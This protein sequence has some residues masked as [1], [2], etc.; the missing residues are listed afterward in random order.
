MKTENATGVPHWDT[1]RRV[2][3]QTVFLG[4]DFGQRP[5]QD[6]DCLAILQ[7]RALQWQVETVRGPRWATELQQRLIAPEPEY[8][9]LTIDASITRPVMPEY[10]QRGCEAALNACREVNISWQGQSFQKVQDLIARLPL[11]GPAARV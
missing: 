1:W 3:A 8:A 2:V 6:R 11:Q 10:W 5:N 7:F 4:L 9:V